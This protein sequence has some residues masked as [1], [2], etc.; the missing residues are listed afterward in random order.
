MIMRKWNFTQ[1][2]HHWQMYMRLY[3][4]LL[5]LNIICCFFN[6]LNGVCCKSISHT[7]DPFSPFLFHFWVRVKNE[8]Q[9]NCWRTKGLK[10]I[11]NCYRNSWAPCHH[12][13][14]QSKNECQKVVIVCWFFKCVCISPSLNSWV[15]YKGTRLF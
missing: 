9:E 1:D 6:S 10:R 13:I 3:S 11:E 2:L 14:K 8:I 12:I 5:F 7:I 4:H 15:L